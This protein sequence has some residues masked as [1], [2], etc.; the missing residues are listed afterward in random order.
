MEYRNEFSNFRE[1]DNLVTKLEGLMEV[2]GLDRKEMFV[3]PD[4]SVFEGTFYK[5]HSPSPKLNEIILRF[6]TAE[7][8]SDCIIHV[9]HIAGT[10]MKVLGID[11]LSRGDI[12]EGMMQLG[13]DTAFERSARVHEWVNSW[14]WN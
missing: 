10:H 9:L 6:R 12:M 14:W 2:G 3:F 7:R 1:A 5:G 11:G 8:Q 13:N 4:N